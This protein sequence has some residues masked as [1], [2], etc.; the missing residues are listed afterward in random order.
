M[1]ELIVELLPAT[2]SGDRREQLLYV[3]AL[4]GLGAGTL[5]CLLAL[6][7]VALDVVAV[8]VAGAGAGTWLLANGA[9]E[10]ETLL[11]VLP[12][13]GITLADLAVLPV[14]LL[15]SYLSVRRWRTR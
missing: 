3:L 8:A 1:R 6:R 9:G 12:G 11:V 10:G 5:L 2:L 14:V 15:V 4:S 13:N 7:V